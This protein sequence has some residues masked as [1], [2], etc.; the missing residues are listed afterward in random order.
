MDF[1]GV[2]M[3]AACTDSISTSDAQGLPAPFLCCTLPS[4]INFLCNDG[5]VDLVGGSFSYL[6]VKFRWAWMSYFVC[7]NQETHW[8]FFF[9]ILIFINCTFATKFK[10][11]LLIT[12]QIMISI[13]IILKNSCQKKKFPSILLYY[14]TN[15]MKISPKIKLC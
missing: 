11:F 9:V 6:R 10:R 2:L 12:I 15:Y 3:Y 14:E 13:L 8:V 7:I 4:S 1:L 5:M